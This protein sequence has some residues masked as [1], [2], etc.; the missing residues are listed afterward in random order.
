MDSAWQII[1]S[2]DYYFRPPPCAFCL[3]PSAFRLVPSALC[4]L[5]S[6]FCL[7]LSTFRLLS[8][9]LCLLPYAFCFLSSATRLLTLDP[10]VVSCDELGITLLQ[11]LI[12]NFFA[13]SHQLIGKIDWRETHLLLGVLKHQQARVRCGLILIDDRLPDPFKLRKRV[14][15]VEFRFETFRQRDRVFNRELCPRADRKM[16]RMQRI[17]K[18]HDILMM[19]VLVLH[20]RKIEPPN[21]VVRKQ[22]MAAQI[23]F[24]NVRQVFTCF[25]VGFPVKAGASPCGF[26]ALDD[27]RAG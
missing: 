16:R 17:A 3:P 10:L 14:R 4:S 11:L 19:P 23:G 6:A 24:E 26:A 27:E 18:Q 5:P 15:N 13:S 2:A 12:V 21:K 8:C 7:L 9:A 25:G 20:Q 22:R 1:E